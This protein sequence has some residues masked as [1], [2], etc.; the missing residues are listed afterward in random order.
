MAPSPSILG[1]GNFKSLIDLVF[2]I[3]ICIYLGSNID[4]NDI[5]PDTTWELVKGRFI[6]G[7]DDEDTQFQTINETGGEK[8]HT[9]TIEEMPYHQHAIIKWA[10][11]NGNDYSGGKINSAMS[12]GAALGGNNGLAYSN[13][14]GGSR[15]H[16]NMPPYIV[17]CIWERTA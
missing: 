12:N 15:A 17:K 10:A 8:T 6:I 5:Y 1:G 16:N 3:G 14:I 11:G 2:P 4:P 7:Y 13:H 9:L